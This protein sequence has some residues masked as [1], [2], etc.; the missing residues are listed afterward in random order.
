MRIRMELV[1]PTIFALQLVEK[2]LVV[3]LIYGLVLGAQNKGG[4]VFRPGGL[5]AP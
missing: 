4:G 2:F 5:G 3:F 1:E